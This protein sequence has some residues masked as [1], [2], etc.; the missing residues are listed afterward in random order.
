MSFH[1]IVLLV[2]GVAFILSMIAFILSITPRKP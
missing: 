1:D 2:L